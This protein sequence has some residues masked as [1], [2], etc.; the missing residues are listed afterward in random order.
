MR[1]SKCK[2]GFAT[3]SKRARCPR[4]GKE[5]MPSTW[6]QKGKVQSFVELRVA[7]QGI[8]GSHNM[9]LVAIEDDGPKI[10]CWTTEILKD[11]DDVVVSESDGKFLCALAPEPDSKAD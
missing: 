5:M 2:C 1:G 9:V 10:I 11:N 4:C 8:E 7:P 6:G 3:T